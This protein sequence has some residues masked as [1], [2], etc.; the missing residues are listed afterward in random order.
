M[1]PSPRQLEALRL[2]AEGYRQREVG[3][4]LGV[5]EQT[6]KNQLQVAYARLGATNAAHAIA[7]LDDRRPGWRMHAEG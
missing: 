2:V 7:I 5:S 6:V 4:R 3:R 1:A